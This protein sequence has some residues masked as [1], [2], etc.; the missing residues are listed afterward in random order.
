MQRLIISGLSGGSGKTIVSLGL[1]RF[2][3][4]QQYTVF[5]FKKGPDYID[6]TWLMHATHKPCYCLDPYFLNDQELYT[7]FYQCIQN[8]PQNALAIIEGNRGIFDGK[9]ELGSCSTAQVAHILDCPILLT[10]NC[11][12]MTRTT[13]AILMGIQNFDPQLKITGV[14]LNNIASKRHGS[15]IQKSIET[16]TDIPVLGIIPRQI[17]NPIPER[18]MGLSLQDYNNKEQIL[19]NL[20]KIIAENTDTT[21]ILKSMENS[22]LK[23]PTFS[24]PAIQ[25][26]QKVNIAYIYDDAIWFY[27]QEN[28]DALKEHGATLYPLSLL[29]EKSFDEQL[30][31]KN[32]SLKNIHALYIGGGYPE[33]F[34]KEI[35]QSPK[36]QQIKSLAENNLPI[37]AECGGFMLCSKAIHTLTNGQY[38]RYPMIGIFDIETKF[39]TKPQGLGYTEAKTINQNPYHSLNLVWKG[40]EFHFSTAINYQEQQKFILEL[41][42]GHGMV[43]KQKAFDGVLYKNCYASYMHL[44]APATPHWAKNFTTLA[45]TYKENIN[46]K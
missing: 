43:K 3:T 20:A 38:E 29:S 42:K 22:P 31:E 12:K 9:D 39:Q 27:Y 19:N 32:I 16:Y 25:K 37:Y 4:N 8:A 36:L 44:Y 35:S 6:A 26:K 34:A 24:F 23:E 1:T 10:I 14:I 7:H 33:L 21:Q 45:N 40:H 11:A 30:L 15:I 41:T 13:A 17:K 5:P 18:H 2:F 46:G 28:L